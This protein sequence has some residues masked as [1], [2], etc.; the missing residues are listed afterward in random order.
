MQCN[1]QYVQHNIQYDIQCNVQH[2]VQ[3]DIQYNVQYDIQ[4]N[5]RNGGEGL[6]VVRLRCD[7]Y[8]PTSN[9]IISN[10][11]HHPHH[12]HWLTSLYLDN[13][14]F[15]W[16]L[17]WLTNV[18]EHVSVCHVWLK[19]KIIYSSDSTYLD[20]CLC[21]DIFGYMFGNIFRWKWSKCLKCHSMWLHVTH[22]SCE[23]NTFLYVWRY[24]DI[25][26]D[27][28]LDTNFA[29]IISVTN[30][31]CATYLYRYIWTYIWSKWLLCHSTWLHV[32]RDSCEAMLGSQ[33]SVTRDS[34][35]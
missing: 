3:Y 23:V 4:Y 28:Y 19:W 13:F 31:W 2:N 15:I 33:P 8:F 12:Q 30:Y 20:I 9:S 22:D 27:T 18:T 24:L 34:I 32:T 1:V 16:T 17:I 11:H 6:C 7:S 29:T 14:G 35:L 26:L 21:L 5:V 10:Q 25:Y